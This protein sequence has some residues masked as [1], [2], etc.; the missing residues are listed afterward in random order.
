MEVFVLR[1]CVYLLLPVACLAQPS[2]YLITT[3]AGNGTAGFSGDGGAATS[4]QLNGPIFVALDSS[5]NLY[6]SDTLNNRIRKVSGGKISTFAGKG[7][8]AYTGDGGQATAAQLSNPY[9]IVVDAKGNLLIA[10]LGNAIVRQVTPGGVISTIAGSYT[11]GSGGDGGPGNL[12][13]D[14]PAVRPGYGFRGESLR[15]RQLLE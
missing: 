11:Y 10:D 13:A 9:G 6:I 5:Q 1:V 7:G 3:V 2:S 14:V 12:G 4:A 8:A 15:Q